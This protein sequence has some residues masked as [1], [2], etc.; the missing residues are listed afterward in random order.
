MKLLLTLPFLTFIS[1]VAN[2]YKEPAK[3]EPHA[4]L[5][6]ETSPAFLGIK[7]PD[8]MVNEIN[9]FT[10]DDTWKGKAAPRR[11]PIGQTH[12]MATA[13]TRSST[14]ATAHLSFR[15]KPGQEYFL[16]YDNGIQTLSLYVKEGE[17]GRV[18]SRKRAAKEL[19]PYTPP[20]YIP[21]YIP[22][23]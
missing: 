17:S 22:S 10:I 14:T 20:T 13:I 5:K 18:V 12:V 11:I 1:C 2:P 15:S 16:G 21:V 8:A 4:V 3:T 23:N 6:C 19:I 7:G 9:G